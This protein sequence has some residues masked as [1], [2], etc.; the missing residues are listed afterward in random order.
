[1]YHQNSRSA[2]EEFLNGSL[3][4]IPLK[5]SEED[6]FDTIHK[7][8]LRSKNINR[9]WPKPGYYFDQGMSAVDDPCMRPIIDRELE[10]PGL[11]SRCHSAFVERMVQSNHTLEGWVSICKAA[12]W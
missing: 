4:L 3:V 6:G 5:T 1:M 9:S 11:L 10:H 8:F 12:I 2:E 7:S